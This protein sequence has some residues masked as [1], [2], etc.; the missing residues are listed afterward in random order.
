[1]KKISLLLSIL[2][3]A[4]CTSVIWESEVYVPEQPE[5]PSRMPS[6]FF[7]PASCVSAIQNFMG[8]GEQD[9]PEF[10]TL[11]EV[12]GSR[13]QGHTIQMGERLGH[14]GRA[15]IYHIKELKGESLPTGI[16]PEDLVLKLAFFK[17]KKGLGSNLVNANSK[18]AIEREYEVTNKIYENR[19]LFRSERHYPANPAWGEDALPV[20]PIMAKLE[21]EKGPGLLKFKLKGKS[22]DDIV[23]HLKNNPMPDE[24]EKS[25]KDIYMWLQ[26]VYRKIGI[27]VDAAAHNL[28]WVDDPVLLSKIGYKRPGFVMFE[29]DQTV[30]NQKAYIMNDEGETSAID[31]L[32]SGFVMDTFEKF[33]DQYYKEE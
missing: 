9:I 7:R 15:S 21:T 23:E 12:S 32:R 10:L 19:E 18:K 25:L 5:D 31:E 14:G 30:L 24:W 27:N 4:S 26:S 2:I 28:M 11:L 29:A 20:L 33:K 1:M 13:V 3:L 8:G 6:S 16:E 17:K 22:F